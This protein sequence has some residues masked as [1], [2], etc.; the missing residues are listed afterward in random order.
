MIVKM[1]KAFVVSRRAEE[2]R[3][4]ESLRELGVIHIE[5]I[6]SAKA[7]A[8]AGT[9]GQIDHLGRA[10]QYVESIAP[11]GDKPEL[12]AIAAAEEVMEI[13]HYAGESYARLS[14]L[15]RQIEHLAMWGDVRLEQFEL[16]SRKGLQVHLY[17]AAAETAAQAGSGGQVPLSRPA[18]Q[19]H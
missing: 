2:N 1:Q 17:S 14:E 7:V 19:G 12:D 3:L 9:L 15:H 11:E 10:L 6:N 8:S 16:L 18:A 13:Q 5:P 4:L